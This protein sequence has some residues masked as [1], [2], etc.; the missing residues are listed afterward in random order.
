[1]TRASNAS[2]CSRVYPDVEDPEDAGV[3]VEAG[4]VDDQP[5][6]RRASADAFRDRVVGRLYDRR[7]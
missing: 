3:V 1:M 2:P 5:F 7:S 4:G 6:G